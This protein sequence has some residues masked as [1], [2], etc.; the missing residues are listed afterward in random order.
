MAEIYIGENQIGGGGTPDLSGYYTKSEIDSSFADTYLVKIS[1]ASGYYCYVPR[2]M[3]DADRQ[4]VLSKLN[5][6]GG[7]VKTAYNT[8][9]TKIGTNSNAEGYLCIAGGNYSHAEGTYTTASGNY[10]HAEGGS[11]T[12]A[13]GT[14]SHAEGSDTTASGYASHAEG[15]HTK[16]SGN[17][18]HAEG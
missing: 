14:C 1:N 16:A 18:S 4:L 13:S 2:T 12:T 15:Y 8:T 9:N 6:N 11:N 3:S 10:S 7:I 5:T 17:Y